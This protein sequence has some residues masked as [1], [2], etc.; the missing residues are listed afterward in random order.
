MNE[1]INPP[2]K[3]A[4]VCDLDPRYLELTNAELLELVHDHGITL[5]IS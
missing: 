4:N 3:D 5:F 2:L 1:M